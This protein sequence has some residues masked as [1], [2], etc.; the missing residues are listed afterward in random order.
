MLGLDTFRHGQVWAWL[1]SKGKGFRTTIV[2]LLTRS[3]ATSFDQMHNLSRTLRAK[4]EE[5]YVIDCG[6]VAEDTLS[7]DGTRKLL[8]EFQGAHKVECASIAADLCDLD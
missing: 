6:N 8:L 2:C 1:Y 3:G 5:K 7:A 4:L